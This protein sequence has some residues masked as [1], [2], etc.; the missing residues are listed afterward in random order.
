MTDG[1][2]EVD[3]AWLWKLQNTLEE[4]LEAE[5]YH[6][7]MDYIERVIDELETEKPPAGNCL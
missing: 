1:T 7:Q 5:A 3:G 2:V 6:E 4:A